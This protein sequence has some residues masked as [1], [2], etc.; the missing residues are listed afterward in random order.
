LQNERKTGR[1][2]GREGK[3]FRKFLSGNSG[4]TAV[5][6]RR[7]AFTLVELLVTIAIIGVLVALLLPAVQMARESARRAHCHNN[8]RQISIAVHHCVETN[9]GKLPPYFGLFPENGVNS[10]EGGWFVHLLPFLEQ[11][12]ITDAIINNGGGIG[13]TRTLVTAASD[14]YMP[15]HYEY[16]A[17]G[18]WETV[19]GTGGGGSDH[20]GHT[21]SQTTAA[22]RVWI[23]PP[24]VLVAAVGSAPVYRVKNNGL[25]A[26]N[27]ASFNILQCTSDPSQA[28]SKYRFP[29]RFGQ[30]SLSNYQGN[31]HVF[32]YNGS[33]LRTRRLEQVTDGTSHTIL[34]AEGMRLC[35][36][37]Y[38]MALWGH[39]QHQ[40]SHN[41]GVDWNGVPNT[42]MFQSGPNYRTCNNWRVQGLHNG[43]LSVAFVDGSVRTLGKHL[44][45]RETSD[46]DHPQWGVDPT[47]GSGPPGVWDKLMLPE[48]G[49]T[50]E[51]YE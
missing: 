51:S 43:R 49:Q 34:A 38:R 47:I 46:P 39:Y 11:Q 16:P 7:R 36:G 1:K 45:R 33:R 17:D 14:D 27:N 23:G 19:P 2:K 21:Y 24:P 15:A 3:D 41:F 31:F 22:N 18:H 32:S 26:V 30:W 6:I 5:G 25:D 35:D 8:L 48:D 12:L 10:V 40:H 4:G 29:F 44:S 13:Q 20:E 37:T 9:R 42:F 50:V 28:S